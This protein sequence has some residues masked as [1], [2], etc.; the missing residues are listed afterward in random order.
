MRGRLRCLSTTVGALALVLA[1]LALVQLTET[2][3]IRFVFSAVVTI[4]IAAFITLLS[5]RVLFA[6]LVTLALVAAISCLS[7]AKREGMNMALHSYDF[8]FYASF[9]TLSF[10]WAD[11]RYYLL[12]AIL[13]VAGAATLATLA[14]RVDKLRCHRVAS[15]AVLAITTA[16][17]AWS[18]PQAKA[19]ISVHQIFGQDSAASITVFYLSWS[20][21]FDALTGGKSLMA[22]EAAARTTLPGFT[23]P[24][25]CTPSE[26]PP[27]IVLI[28]QESIFPPSIFPAVDYDRNLDRF[29]FSDDNKLH[30]LRVETYGG[31]SWVTDFSLFTGVSALSFGYIRPFI[32]VFLNG[33]LKETLPQW[34]GTC[35]YRNL[36][37]FPFDGSFIALEKFYLSMGF[38]K[39]FD[40][41]AQGVKS[42]HERDRVYFQNALNAAEQHLATSRAPLFLYVQTMTAHGPY[43]QARWPEENVSGG[44]AGTSAELNEY[45]RR[46]AI[47]SK[48]GEFLIDELKRRFPDERFLIVRFG[49]HQPSATRALLGAPADPHAP[50]SQSEFPDAFITFYALS[51]INFAVRSLPAFEALDIPFLDTVILEAARLPLTEAQQERKRLMQVCAGQYF[52][53]K[54]REEILTFHRRL[55]NSAIVQAR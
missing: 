4:S 49:D 8:L 30:K 20:E 27:N 53:C 28:H 45:L 35:G 9:S 40:R 38:H 22:F 32:P 19:P 50:M 52:Q 36:L 33:R 31:A 1:T 46:L 16:A 48:D 5:R 10:L 29:F 23:T 44:G 39:V 43:D 54:H 2:T 26:K 7:Y 25:S 21:T 6:S 24:T 13:F 47:V 3:Q 37:F 14:W 15:G 18:G 34:L 41:N 17:T 12:G 51:G 55:I 11:Y 42:W